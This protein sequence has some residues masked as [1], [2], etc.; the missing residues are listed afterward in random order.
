M[1]WLELMTLAY[2]K[3]M[4]LRRYLQRTLG[5][6]AQCAAVRAKW[7]QQP[8][9]LML[10]QSRFAERNVEAGSATEESEMNDI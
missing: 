4:S 10:G 5:R 6:V 9:T 1:V 3:P 2:V 8:T 7:R